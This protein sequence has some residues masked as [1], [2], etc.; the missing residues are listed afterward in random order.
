MAE[1]RSAR[2]TYGTVARMRAALAGRGCAGAGR[3]WAMV[4]GLSGRGL[5]GG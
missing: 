3:A 1:I 5:R 4:G 2:D